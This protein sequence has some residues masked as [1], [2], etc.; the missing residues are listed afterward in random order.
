MNRRSFLR[1]APVAGAVIAAPALAARLIPGDLA[2]ALMD[3]KNKY[4]ALKV[5][6]EAY[7]ANPRK[8]PIN[9]SAEYDAYWDAKRICDRAQQRFMEVLA[10]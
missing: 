6:W 1:A 9:P 8:S 10:A 4:N 3:Y 2:L 5:A 7:E